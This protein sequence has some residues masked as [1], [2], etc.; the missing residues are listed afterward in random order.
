MTTKKELPENHI[1][2][3]GRSS[4]AR[5]SMHSISD[6][7]Q[8]FSPSHENTNAGKQKLSEAISFDWRTSIPGLPII[9]T[10]KEYNKDFLRRDLTAGLSVAVLLIPQSMA[11]AQL[12]DLPPRYGL[13]SS[14]VPVFIYAIFS[15]TSMTAIGPVAPTCIM[16]SSALATIGWETE[17][18]AVEIATA[19]TF[20][21]GIIFS[22]FAFFQ[23]GFIVKFLSR[24]VMQ[25][26]CTGAAFI[27]ASSQLKGLLKLD[28]EKTQYF[29]STFGNA[30]SALDSA[31]W[32]TAVFS[33]LASAILIGA[34]LW[35]VPRWIP[36]P[37]ML[38]VASIVA[39]VAFDLESHGFELVGDIPTGLPGFALPKFSRLSESSIWINS[40]VLACVL[41][42]AS[43]GLSSSFAVQRE[44]KIN[45]NQ[46]IYAYSF[47]HLV[48][49]FFSSH[50]VSASFSRTALNAELDNATQGSSFIQGSTIMMALLFLTAPIE[51]LPKCVLSAVIIASVIS[52][53]KYEEWL[54]LYRVNKPDCVCFSVTV[55]ATLVIGIEP[56]ILVG[57]LTNMMFLI[58]RDSTPGFAE[59]RR[60]PGTTE[61]VDVKRFT[62]VE[63]IND[64][65]VCQFRNELFYANVDVFENYMNDLIINIKPKLIIV[66]FSLVPYI[67]SNGVRILA[68]S[69][70]RAKQYDI[71]IYVAG[72]RWNVRDAIALGFVHLEREKLRFFLNV[73][74]ALHY[75]EDHREFQ[76][77]KETAEEEQEDFPAKGLEDSAES[78][79]DGTQGESRKDRLNSNSI[80]DEFSEKNASNV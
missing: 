52:L 35:K 61:Y 16:I 74:S 19:M 47:A 50:V 34:K 26:F 2:L 62:D 31:H 36:V 45:A 64:V 63:K 71:E 8:N 30:V 76:K 66:D 41:Y 60:L 72:T 56:G 44:Q 65:H 18:E 78:I 4:T 51:K 77:L 55:I 28:M 22:I 23:L 11:Y 53:F 59:L 27:I 21:V 67:D 25:G 1:E 6:T 42:L 57:V 43:I 13:Y 29:Y 70:T 68:Q 12:A 69:M 54:F 79:Q 32:Q 20:A 46:E 9:K 48:G 37:L 5:E 15:D 73:D 33:F 40:L 80:G 58:A 38:M 75:W 24:P 3:L 14:I 17:E 7:L 49:C 39:S 10:F